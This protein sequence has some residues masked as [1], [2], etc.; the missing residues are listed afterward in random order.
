MEQILLEAMLRHTEDTEVIQDI[1]PGFTKGKS[2]LTN[3]VA[4]YNV[5]ITS[6]D[7]GRV[8]EVIY[9]DFSKAFD[10]VPHSILLSK[11]ERYGFDGWTAW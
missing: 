7:K 1:Q 11:L 6:V 3:R 2:C 5:V 8:M 10:T 9:L 4:F